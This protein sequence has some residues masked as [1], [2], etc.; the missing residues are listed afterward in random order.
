MNQKIQLV[1]LFT[2]LTHLNGF[3]INQTTLQIWLDNKELFK[4]FDLHL[5]GREIKSISNSTFKGMTSLEFIDLSHN[6]LSYLPP[7]LFHGLVKLERISMYYNQLKTLDEHQFFGLQNLRYIDLEHNQI[8]NLAPNTFKSLKML[9]YLDLDNNRLSQI[10]KKFLA[11]VNSL[12]Y[13]FLKNNNISLIEDGFIE[14]FNELCISF[15]YFENNECDFVTNL[16]GSDKCIRINSTTCDLFKTQKLT[17]KPHEKWNSTGKEIE[18]LRY[19]SQ[20]NIINFKI[21]Y[22]I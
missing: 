17:K 11:D 1:I 20:S 22:L 15:F 13:F 18:K 7:S 19:K 4:L 21:E 6:K 5:S 10:D 14:R 2:M 12:K 9:W 16:H 3:N 8:A